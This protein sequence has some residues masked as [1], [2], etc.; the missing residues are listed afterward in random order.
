MEFEKVTVIDGPNG[1]GTEW[2]TTSEVIISSSSSDN[3]INDGKQIQ[4][5]PLKMIITF[6]QRTIANVSFKYFLS[7][8]LETTFLLDFTL[9]FI[10]FIVCYFSVQRSREN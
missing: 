10:K 3:D 4:L 8:S 7:L 2:T 1:N 9:V 6:I 5:S